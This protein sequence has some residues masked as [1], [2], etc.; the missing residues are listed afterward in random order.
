MQAAE[1]INHI[2]EIYEKYST[3]QNLRRHMIWV[4]A[5]AEELCEN[6]KEKTDNESII[7]ACLTHD[8]G[9][10][11]KMDFA[12]PAK[13]LLLDKI[14]RDNIS[15]LQEKK[16]EFIQKY[17]VN[18]GAAN[19]KIIREI[20]T[21]KKVIEL[22]EKKSIEKFSLDL[23]TQNID[24][25]IFAYADLRVDPH[26]V[27]TLEER[28]S[29]FEK[30]YDLHKDTNKMEQSKKFKLLARELEK[31]LF[32]KI[33]ITPEQINKESIKKYT[34]KYGLKE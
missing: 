2:K 9:N 18:D 7:A 34:T 32:L 26:G 16:K 3:P 17:G 23:W 5:V 12:D 6:A 4:A 28:L 22:F 13:I 27:V 30:R 25:M 10:F 8:L 29:E 15:F 33:K 31:M 14:D 1:I 11:V 19:E 20:C 21:D 24:L